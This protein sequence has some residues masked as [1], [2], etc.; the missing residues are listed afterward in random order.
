MLYVVRMCFCVGACFCA[1]VCVYVCAYVC[2]PVP[3]VCLPV[4]M[5]V[6]VRMCVH[7]VC[8]FS[9]VCML[10]CIYTG[11]D[12]RF[13]RGGRIFENFD[14]LFFEVD[15]IDFPSSPKA[16]KRPCFGQIFC[17]A[18]NFFEEKET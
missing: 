8:V 10:V 3:Y 16:V 7:G 14:E 2:V 18:G 13:S 9:C 4:C 17:A 6:C 12:L 5:C 11:A 1:S 15:Q